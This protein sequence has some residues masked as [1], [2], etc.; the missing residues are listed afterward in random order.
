MNSV[1]SRKNV[2]LVS[3]WKVEVSVG[4]NDRQSRQ[5]KEVYTLPFLDY[6]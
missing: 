3:F 6:D 5:Q 4:L 2:C 1:D